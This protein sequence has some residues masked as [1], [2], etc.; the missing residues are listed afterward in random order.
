VLVIPY[1]NG[2]AESMISR[3]LLLSFAGLLLPVPSAF[4][5]PSQQSVLPKKADSAPDKNP[6]P[7]SGKVK[8]ILT[9]GGYT[10]V[11]L[12]TGSGMVWAAFPTVPVTV[13]QDLTLV[14][15]Y[16]MRNFSSKSLNRKFDRIIFSSGPMEKQAWDPNLLKVAHESGGSGS[17]AA[18]PEAETQQRAT[19]AESQ[20]PAP[21]PPRQVPRE[22]AAKMPPHAQPKLAEGVK[23]RKASGANAYT[24]K[25][26]YTRRSNLNGKKIVV[27]GKVVKVNPRI[28]KQCWIHIQD[29]TG[30]SGKP[31]ANLVTTT[32][33]TN[34][35]IPAVGDV[36]TVT[37]TLRKDRDY[38]SGY[39]YSVIIENSTYRKE[40]GK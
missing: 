13:G 34:M 22:A 27:R 31:D 16:E 5:E 40:S 33:S 1:A 8:E 23:V 32:S 15:G 17:K 25:D 29:G 36:V 9:S 10:Y 37:G 39:K 3:L 2:I 38:G 18:A 28:L 21:Q 4:A 14:P 11:S 6:I 24:V 20:P 30:T 12:A 35:A 7:V 26:L 19:P